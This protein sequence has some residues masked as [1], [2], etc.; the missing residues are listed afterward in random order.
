MRRDTLGRILAFASIVEVGTALI[1]LLDPAIVVKLLLGVEISGTV[2]IVGRCFGIALLALGAAC[3]PSGQTAE[4]RASTFRAM[5]IYNALIAAYLAY[6]YAVEHVGGTL[7]WPGA[8]LHAIV[9]VLLAWAWRHGRG[10]Q[11]AEK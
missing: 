4:R 10:T 9:A 11:M 3:W 1:L 8:A 6:L 5:L 7:L 2:A